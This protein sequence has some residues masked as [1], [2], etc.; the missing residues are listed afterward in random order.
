MSFLDWATGTD[1]AHM[2]HISFPVKV[3]GAVLFFGWLFLTVVSSK[4]RGG[5]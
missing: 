2:S 5:R 3:L 4:G 1:G